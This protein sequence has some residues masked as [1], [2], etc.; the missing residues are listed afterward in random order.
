M[1]ENLILY[2][3]ELLVCW[4]VHSFKGMLHQL[5]IKATLIERWIADR[6][7]SSEKQISLVIENLDIKRLTLHYYV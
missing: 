5:S 3:V 2:L 1:P 6:C 7:H 4:Q